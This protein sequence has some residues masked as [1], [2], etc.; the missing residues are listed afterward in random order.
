MLYIS[1]VYSINFDEPSFEGVSGPFFC[2]YED[3]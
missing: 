2:W 1:S 3:G